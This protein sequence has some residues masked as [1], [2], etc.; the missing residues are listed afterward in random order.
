MGNKKLTSQKVYYLN[1]STEIEHN[2]PDNYI[3]RNATSREP[4]MVS[5][6]SYRNKSKH[7]DNN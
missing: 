1:D 2:H 6:R 7:C 5:K 3:F 4:K